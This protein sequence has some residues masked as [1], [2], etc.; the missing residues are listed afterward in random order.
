MRLAVADNGFE[1]THV[2]NEFGKDRKYCL[3]VESSIDVI[4]VA[5]RSRVS[6]ERKEENRQMSA[7]RSIES[8]KE[9]SYLEEWPPTLRGLHHMGASGLRVC[10]R[11]DERGEIGEW[12]TR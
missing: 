4:K 10:G 5:K 1:E 2:V 11:H 7:Y 3:W 12:M 8:L 9:E 6:F